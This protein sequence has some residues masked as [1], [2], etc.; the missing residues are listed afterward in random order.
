MILAQV[1]LPE[2]FVVL[3]YLAVTAYLGWLGYRG[4]KTATDY[5]IA[6]RKVHPF[7]MALSYGATFIS[8]S[9]IVGFG[10]AAGLFGMS[11]LWLTFCNIFIGIF[12]AFVFLGG[13]TR[14]I[15]R[16]LDAHTF[17]ELLGRR[18]ESKFIQVFAGLVIVAFMPLYGAAVLLG[19]TE[20]IATALGLN[21]DVALF[22]FAVIV[23]AYVFFGGLKAV[24][25]TD[26]LQGAIMFIGM[27]ILLVYTYSKIGGVVEGHK[28]LTD[29]AELVPPSLQAIGHQ[30]WTAM[31]KFGF[32][33]PQ[34]NLWWIV[35]STI[36]MGVGIGVLAQPQLVVRFMTVR[37]KREL[38]RA[39]G[40]G[41]V[42]ILAMTG[43][44]FLTGA[45]SNAYNV[46]HGPVF[47]GRVIKVVNQERGQAFLQLMR[48]DEAGAWMDM[49][50][51]KSLDGKTVITNR[52]QAPVR[53]AAGKWLPVA[54]ATN[55][56]GELLEGKVI[57]AVL[58]KEQFDIAT[59]P[60]AGNQPAVAQARSI[61][62]VIAKGNDAQI[63]PSYITSALP[64]WFGLLFL[65]TLLAAAM[66]TLSSQFH[67]LGTAAGRDVFERLAGGRRASSTR[68]VLIVRV[69]ILVGLIAGVAISHYARGETIIARATAIFFGLCAS[70]FLPAFVGG[71]FWRRMTRAG[72]IASMLSGFGVT[73][74]WLLFVKVPELGAFG[75]VAQSVLADRPNWPVV[76][77]LI[78]ALPVSIVT[79]IVVSLFTRPPSAELLAK[80]FPSAM[81]VAQSPSDHPITPTHPTNR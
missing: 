5:M 14:R 65:L 81:S 19:G 18:Y 24:M 68:T 58:V 33:D 26:A 8:T 16:R 56:L 44:A 42:F 38:N 66:S 43:V 50:D 25:Y 37:S 23:A 53:D 35:V 40:I 51:V 67:T 45:L 48:A 60:S 49:V 21:F 32:G 1:G 70:T 20:F 69:A 46:L 9:A 7:V 59:A 57:P 80:C 17:P 28:A 39:V 41:G 27:C 31:P 79:A 6:G 11:L 54:K 61:S 10:G 36:V 63:I 62:I 72:A 47:S 75:L 12:I 64:K 15:G 2:I 73:A 4:T 55:E 78:V 76:D 34:Y 74:A 13:P 71:L 22:L 52:L 30:G 77:P 3:V 29:L